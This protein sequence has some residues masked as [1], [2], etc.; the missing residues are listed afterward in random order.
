MPAA[1]SGFMIW[2]G[3]GIFGL[4]GVCISSLKRSFFFLLFDI[5]VKIS[6]KKIPA[7]TKPEGS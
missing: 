6:S 1:N 5:F 4:V 2:W 3:L 7:F